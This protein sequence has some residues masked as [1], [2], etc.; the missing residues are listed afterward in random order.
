MTE[1]IM[2]R[3]DFV[4]FV[5]GMDHSEGVAWGPDGYVYA[6]G[7]A[8]QI[9]R[10]GLDDG[11][12]EE[13]GKV[14]PGAL[15]ICL[16]ADANVYACSEGTG[17]VFRTT[18]EGEVSVYSSGLPERKMAVPNYPVFDRAGNMYVSDSNE[19]DGA[20]GCIFRIKPGG[21][22]EVVSE[23][24]LQFPNGMALSPDGTELYIVE[25]NL[26]GVSK[27]PI[28]P[29]GRLGPIEPVVEMP[30]IV[31]DGVAFDVQ[32]NLYISCY[33]PGRIY[34]LSPG[35]E[36]DILFDDWQGTLLYGPTNITFGGAD[37]STMVTSNIAG[38]WLTK[39]QMPYPGIPLPYPKL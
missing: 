32:D 16:D 12:C 30:R 36:L 2:K 10:V 4:P 26:P 3:D 39:V 27:A 14:G 24:T 11:S 31:P 22:T 23:G 38:T 20:N 29:D 9:Y 18:Q 33:V 15:G 37:L 28:L 7:E 1:S 21:E 6:D 25:T 17:E 13:I 8:G 5:Y 19:W 35:G 34:R